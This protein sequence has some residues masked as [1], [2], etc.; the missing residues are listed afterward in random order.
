MEASNKYAEKAQLSAINMENMTQKMSDI[1]EKTETET[2][3]MR[4]ITCVTL[5]FLPG[6]FMAVSVLWECTLERIFTYLQAL[7]STPIINYQKLSEEGGYSWS[8]IGVGALKLYAIAS[9]PLVFITFAAWGIMDL[10]A[11]R[12]RK[13]RKF[14]SRDV[15][16]GGANELK[17]EKGSPAL[18]SP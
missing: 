16:K 15:E 11:R 14:E 10:S 13:K 8:H 12:Q 5:F 17:I 7:F 18:S 3:S 9:L 4:I 1:A 2:V 6:T